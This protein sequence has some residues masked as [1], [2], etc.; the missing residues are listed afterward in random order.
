MFY[1]KLSRFF[2]M[3]KYKA[4]STKKKKRKHFRGSKTKFV[5]FTGITIFKENFPP[6]GHAACV[7]QEG[8]H[9]I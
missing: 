8:P 2:F 7:C 5:F 4:Y 1:V 9:R 6:F 3:A